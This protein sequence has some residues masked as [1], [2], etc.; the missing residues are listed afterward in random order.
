MKEGEP[1]TFQIMEIEQMKTAVDVLPALL[2]DKLEVK[3]RWE[4]ARANFVAAN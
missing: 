3:V 2:Q 4:P 1:Q